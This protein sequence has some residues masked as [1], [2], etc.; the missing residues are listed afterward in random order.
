MSIGFFT[1][2]TVAKPKR[3]STRTKNPVE[4]ARRMG[5]AAVR[6]MNPKAKSPEMEPWGDL[7]ADVLVML[8]APRQE[9]DKN[10]RPLSCPTGRQYKKWLTRCGDFAVDHLCRTAPPKGRGPNETELAAFENVV[11]EHI[12]DQRPKV[13]IACGHTVLKWFS[14]NVKYDVLTHR[15]RM[16]PVKLE[17]H[18]FWVCPVLPPWQ[19]E[20]IFEKGNDAAY[21]EEYERITKLD[22]KA[23]F[24]MVGEPARVRKASNFTG[25]SDDCIVCLKPDKGALREFL[26]EEKACKQTTFDIEG[27]RLRPYYSDFKMY[28]FATTGDKLTISMPFDHPEAQVR[29]MK[30]VYSFVED[31]FYEWFE[32]RFVTAHNLMFDLEVFAYLFGIDI[33]DTAKAWECTQVASFCLDQ[34]KGQSLDYLSRLYLGFSLKDLSPSDLWSEKFAV[35]ELLEY[36]AGDSKGTHLIRRL[37]VDQLKAEGLFDVW[38]FRC[39][40]T[41]ALIQTQLRGLPVSQE[42][43]VVI[44][45]EY[46]DQ[47]AAIEHKL[48]ADEGVQQYEEDHGKFQPTAPEA[49][50]LL[51]HHYLGHKEVLSQSK[52]ARG[53]KYST[54][55][56]VMSKFVDVEPTAKPILEHRRI[57]KLLSTYLRRYLISEKDSYVFPDGRVHTQFRT[58][59]ADGGRLASQDP[60][61]QNLPNRGE[62]KTTRKVFQ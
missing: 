57:S 52:K 35:R 30:K 15:G 10:G 36:G 5:P 47:L 34:R 2:Q 13:V 9:D 60:N 27:W 11:R 16:F 19:A 23:A 59:N 43:V 48:G 4:T 51:Y 17:D 46:Q 58:T 41:P 26:Q 14:P 61:L 31:F 3:H 28:S 56:P 22:I 33:L 37:M 53:S 54:G 6:R 55:E 38:R 7:D 25:K 1:R 8:D 24:G 18:S 39:E 62:G 42:Q 50:G 40:R 20:T 12:L 45:S 29:N 21:G 49:V 44:Q 32:G